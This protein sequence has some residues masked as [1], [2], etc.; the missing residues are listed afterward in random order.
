MF[1]RYLFTL[2]VF[3]S[4]A[5]VPAGVLAADDSEGAETYRAGSS[6][7]AVTGGAWLGVAVFEVT[8]GVEHEGFEMPDGVMVTRIMPG[9]PAQGAGLEPGDV[10]VAVDGE[11]VK[12][13]D[14]F[15]SVIG[16][17]SPGDRVTIEV[18]RDGELKSLYADLDTRPRGF[19]SGGYSS[20]HMSGSTG[21]GDHRHRGGAGMSPKH[22]RGCPDYGDYDCPKHKRGCAGYGKHECGKRMGRGHHKFPGMHL[23]ASVLDLTDEQKEKLASIRAEYRKTT[24]RLDADIEVAEVELKEL[25]AAPEMDLGQVEEKIDEISDKNAELRLYRLKTFSDVKKLL[26]P[27]QLDKLRWPLEGARP[28]P[29]GCG[30]R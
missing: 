4:L 29:S 22:K 11:A 9:S 21:C 20:G 12:S 19:A 1:L 15:V 8:D 27:A 6:A 3:A 30:G 26:T 16:S 13:A 24:I 28:G 18:N 10:I 5:F 2:F 14:K 17:R 7:V 25:V 23:D